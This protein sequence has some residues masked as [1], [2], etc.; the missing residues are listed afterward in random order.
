MGA[1]GG[2]PWDEDRNEFRLGRYRGNYRQKAIQT[3]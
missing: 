3:R 2:I 1:N